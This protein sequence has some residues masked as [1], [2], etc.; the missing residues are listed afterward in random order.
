VASALRLLITDPARRRK[1]GSQ[2]PSQAA[3]ISDPGRQL[4]VLRQLLSR[5]GGG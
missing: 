3:R 5:G 1:L 4:E 2:G